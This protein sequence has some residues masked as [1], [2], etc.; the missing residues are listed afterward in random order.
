MNMMY[1]RGKGRKI[2]KNSGFGSFGCIGLVLGFPFYLLVLILNRIF[3]NS[4]H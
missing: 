4:S 2:Y 3:R 1:K